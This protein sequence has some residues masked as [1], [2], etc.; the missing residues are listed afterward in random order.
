MQEQQAERQLLELA[1]P[2]AYQAVQRRLAGAVERH[3]GR[4]AQRQAGHLRTHE[5]HH[6]TPANPP[7][8]CPGQAQRRDGVGQE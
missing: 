5:R 8:Q 2:T 4:Q 1:L 7:G 6:A 3:R